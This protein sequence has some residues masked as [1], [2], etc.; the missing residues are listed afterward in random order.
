MAWLESGSSVGIFFCDRWST[1]QLGSCGYSGGLVLSGRVAAADWGWEA[2][3]KGG[4]GQAVEYF[5]VP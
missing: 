1:V 3:S 5:N 4:G 2:E